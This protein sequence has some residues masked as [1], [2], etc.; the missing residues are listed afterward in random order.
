MVRW[1]QHAGVYCAI[2]DGSL[3]EVGDKF[4]DEELKPF[5]PLLA[6]HLSHPSPSASKH[7]LSKICSL[8]VKSGL[9]PYLTMDYQCLENMLRLANSNGTDGFNNYGP[10]QKLTTVCHALQ[11]DESSNSE[12]WLLASLCEENIEELG[13][14]LSFVFLNIPN[15]ISIEDLVTKLLSIKD[16]SELL[17]QVVANVSELF[18]P[19]VSYLLEI[20]PSD[21]TVSA[22]RQTTITNL[23]ALNPPLSHSILDRMAELRKEC[24]FATR[25]VCEQLD[26]EAVCYFL[27]TYLLDKKGQVSALIGKSATKHTVSVVLRRL[28][29]MVSVAV[30]K[31]STEPMTDVLLSII[32]LCQRCSMKLP[33]S[34]LTLITSFICRRDVAYDGHLST[35]LAAL[36][37]TPTLTFSGSVP[38][39]LSYQVERHISE[40][41]EW[42]RKKTEN[43]YC[44]AFAKDLLNVGLGIVGGQSDVICGY[45]AEIL[46][47]PKVSI[48]QR[49]MEQ[50]K[51]LFVDS[52]LS[53]ADL[54]ARCANLPITPSL[55]SSSECA[56]LPITPSLS[57]SSG[58]RLTI[59]VMAELMSANAFTKYSVDISAWMQAQIIELSLPMHPQ[60]IELT[61]CFALEAAQKKVIG[62]SQQFVESVFSGD[63]LDDSKLATRVLVLLYLLYYKRKVDAIKEQGIY[64]NDVYMRL[65]IRYLLSVVEIRYDDFAKARCHLI[66]LVTELF[67]HMLPTVESIT[68]AKSRRVGV[69]VKY[70]ELGESL[71]SPNS[72]V[73]MAAVQCLDS[74]SLTDQIRLIPNL[75]RAFLF[76]LESVPQPYIKI[77]VGV[78]NRL[79]N[80]VPRMLFEHCT[81]SWSSVTPTQC[82]QHPC[83][84]FRCDR[85]PKI[86]IINHIVEVR[87]CNM[88][89]RRIFLSPLHFGCFLKMVSFYDQACRSQ[90]MLQMQ[91]ASSLNDEERMSRDVLAH[92]FDHSQ[93]SILVQVLIEVSDAR[94]MKDAPNDSSAIARRCAIRKLACEFIHQM[95]IQDKNL[96][97]LVLFQTWPIDMIRPLVENIPSMFVATDFIQE[98][99]ALP[100]LKRRIFAV[101]LMAEYRLPESAASLNLVIDVLNT[102]LKY[103]QMP[104]NHALFT[105]ITPSLGH[106]IPV[107]PSLAP[108]VSTLLLRIA[109]TTRSQ[110]AMN[111]LDAYPRSSQ[112]R[113]LTNTIERVLTSRVFVAD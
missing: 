107:Y 110:L 60:I 113:K 70:D 32:Y 4:S 34:D 76:S 83:L 9:M 85:F 5:L 64:Q 88:C 10:T 89:Y 84:L 51:T 93:T 94:R 82:Y 26:D 40:W 24:M 11:E 45:F 2:V 54:T 104:G 43:D 106:I 46:K 33:P 38:V 28:L 52:C 6:S 81:L 50:W 16:G 27:R 56:N 111:C 17:T 101:C 75:A 74:A 21:Q 49:Q 65:P 96:M 14:M 41:L 105:A 73:A 87:S 7:F 69:R 29:K 20:A 95:F 39:A 35:A 62:L 3:A 59:H 71:C 18:L 72:T 36:I 12:E 92:A 91:N 61:L 97:K 53:E 30:E 103:S 77:I 90:L 25:V 100:D 86:F 57:S 23:V 67:P 55:S 58:N 68:I 102:L 80:V 13:W 79:E 63:L 15:I 22:A 78:W 8:I 99:L 48:N 31:Q 66:R 109:S 108:L 112:E 37:A 98:M 1:E 42:I 19:M 47:L 44:S